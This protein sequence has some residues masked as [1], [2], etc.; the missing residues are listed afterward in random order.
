[1]KALHR[2]AMA[3]AAVA[4]VAA[5][6]SAA[7]AQQYQAGPLTI[8]QPWA[9]ASMGDVK[10]TAAYMKI[11]N[12]GEAADKLTAAKSEV[13]EHVM[14]HESRMEGDVMKMVHVEGGI[15]VP[16][17]GSAELKPLGL[18]VML[19][20]LKRPL[21]EGETFPMTLVFEKEGE[22]GIEVKVGQAPASPAAG[23]EG[24][25]Q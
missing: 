3:L 7:V 23:H 11:A 15:E 1:M 20:G 19:M 13:A 17:H 12:S 25:D 18:H 5:A 14:L 4:A 2:L 16:A 6:P 9:R 21:K 24:H 10:N 22:V 8:E